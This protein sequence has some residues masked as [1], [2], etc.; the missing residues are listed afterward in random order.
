[1]PSPI[2]D[3]SGI[4]PHT[5]IVLRTRLDNAIDNLQP[6]SYAAI[7]W[8]QLEEEPNRFERLGAERTSAACPVYNCHGLTFGNRRTQV[9]GSAGTISMIL[10]DDG[11]LE[12]PV[13]EA[14]LGDIVIYY[15]GTGGVQ[16]SGIVIGKGALSVP[17]VWSKWGKGYEMVHALGLCPY[18]S[19]FAR[20]YRILKWK[21]EEV[22]AKNS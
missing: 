5:T 4:P 20:F 13:A 14:R 18:D 10:A 11:F 21:F 12:V 1:M 6:W 9:D 17:K 15:D 8:G 2:L 3:A 7:E 16:H 22:F 19:S